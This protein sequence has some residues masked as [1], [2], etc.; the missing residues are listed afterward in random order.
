MIRKSGNLTNRINLDYN[1]LLGSAYLKLRNRSLKKG[2]S[3]S[4]V[5]PYVIKHANDLLKSQDSVTILDIGCSK[6][7]MLNSINKQLSNNKISL[8]GADF[9]ESLLQKARKSYKD[10]KFIKHDITSDNTLNFD[11]DIALCVNTLHE[12]YSLYAW[13]G[14]FDE[15]IGRKYLHKSL[16]NIISSIKPGGYFILFDGVESDSH[17]EDEII[18]RVKSEEAIK[19]MHKFQAEYL[20]L[21][22]KIEHINDNIYK[23]DSKS[24]TRFIT[25]YRFLTNETW[26]LEKVESYQ[27][28][29]E[30]EFEV[31]FDKLGLE[32]ETI[33]LLNP[34]INKWRSIIEIL[35][36]NYSFPNEHI[37]IIGRKTA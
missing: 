19:L 21:N 7:D 3:K 30:D 34:N 15:N 2:L 1:S 12:V 23:T 33:M 32:T 6:G 35:P 17:T 14:T 31:A 4:L 22:V 18:F 27:Y 16:K 25:K 9:N 28:F 8:I 24:F 37:L 10:I 13:N 20:P 26:E 11:V 5:I 29:T 36:D